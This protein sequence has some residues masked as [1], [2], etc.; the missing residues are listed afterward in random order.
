MR[1]AYRT[2]PKSHKGDTMKET[3][4]LSPRLSTAATLIRKGATLVDVGTDHA[5][6][7]IY[8]CLTGKIQGGAVSD[9]NRGPI[10]R[11]RDNIKKYGLEQRLATKQT[12]GLYGMETAKPTDISI[13]GMGGELIARIIDDAPLVK[14]KDIQL[15]LQP[16]THPELLRAYLCENGFEII[17]ERLVRDDKIYQLILARYNGKSY[18]L[19]AEELLLGR[20]NIQRG[21]ELLTELAEKYIETLQKQIAGIESA[22][23]SADAQRS[24]IK[25]LEAVIGR[26]DAATRGREDAIDAF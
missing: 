4:T 24:M 17:D 10:E 19:S 6:L 21:G 13:L 26:C 25:R 16:M 11:A 12:D 15:C 3:L 9:I 22:G 2:V 14:N 8:L 7:P 18:E 20:V 1:K 5:Y 23:K